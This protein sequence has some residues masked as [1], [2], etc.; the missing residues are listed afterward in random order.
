[1]YDANYE[2][3][4]L[5]DQL[6]EAQAIAKDN[7]K[8]FE[9]A[10]YVMVY[11][12]NRQ[13]NNL[14]K[15]YEILKNTQD[16]KKI[17]EITRR[18]NIIL[19]EIPK[20]KQLIPKTLEELAEKFKNKGLDINVINLKSQENNAMLEKF[21][22]IIRAANIAIWKYCTAYET[23]AR[24]QAEIEKLKQETKNKEKIDKTES[25]ISQNIEEQ[26]TEEPEFQID[27][28]TQKEILSILDEELKKEYHETPKEL[29]IR[30]YNL[31]NYLK[32][33]YPALNYG[34]YYNI[35]TIKTCLEI[36]DIMDIYQKTT[37]LLS[38][39][40][41][42]LS[43]L[44]QLVLKA[45]EIAPLNLL[46]GAQT[47]KPEYQ[48]Y[49]KLFQKINCHKVLEFYEKA[50]NIFV[51]YYNKLSEKEKITLIKEI[52][53]NSYF[54]QHQEIFNIS[55]NSLIITP[56]I[57]VYKVNQIV[58]NKMIKYPTSNYFYE[59]DKD[60]DIIKINYATK[61]M[62][63][64]E[65]INIYKTRKTNIK[66]YKF[67]TN[68]NETLTKITKS[69]KNLQF[70]FA[71]AILNR[72]KSKNDLNKLN[73]EEK[74][75]E[76]INICHQC[77]NEKAIFTTRQIKDDNYLLEYFKKMNQFN[78]SSLE[79]SKLSKK[80]DKNTDVTKNHE[81]TSNS[82]ITT[83]EESKKTTSN[84]ENIVVSKKESNPS[85]TVKHNTQARFFGLNK[86][87]QT[88]LKVTGKWEKFE[89][90]WNTALTKEK[91]EQEKITEELN[92][93]FGGH[94]GNRKF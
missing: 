81:T 40:S 63:I 84:I 16:L 76:L 6:K 21:Q 50:Y 23:I 57:L 14:H 12:N 24:C 38:K 32:S 22:D 68:S 20:D 36:N 15:Q 39:E 88:Y 60:T 87:K 26:T 77:F 7:F 80:L 54:K 55:N 67:Q 66:T 82:K 52:K 51:N 59:S 43:Y 44:Y 25:P 69:L 45:Y 64:D 13:A 72:L 58:H 65:I 2:I 11:K 41:P 93:L 48:N 62:N 37:N 49:E 56:S 90:I 18:I 28:Y 27:I 19:N 71:N 4:S 89:K 29:G 17:Q 3:T 70:N 75:K 42:N 30:Y 31:E 91:E 86:L 34:K 74:N 33:A 92:R 9:I 79:K 78:S 47:N 5:Q 46:N 94:D 53:D 1:M 8:I 10:K 83:T 73:A 85:I 35:A 61:Y